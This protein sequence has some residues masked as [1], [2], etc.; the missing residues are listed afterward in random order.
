M[1]QL[2]ESSQPSMKWLLCFLILQRLRGIR[3]FAQGHTAKWGAEPVF[4]PEESDSRSYKWGKGEGK[5]EK[6][7]GPPQP[8][9]QTPT[10]HS[11]HQFVGSRS[12]PC[13]I[14]LIIPPFSPPP[15]LP[16]SCNISAVRAI[17]TLQCMAFNMY[18]SF[19]A[20]LKCYLCCAFLDPILTQC[21]ADS[22][23]STNLPKWR[24]K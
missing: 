6:R 9:T 3:W 4:E 24:Q 1:Y 13:H 14:S 8:S 19:Q 20:Q 7:E 2:I 10:W 18:S 22:R 5:E 12:P 23:C 21:P 11:G 17:S 15:P 16:E